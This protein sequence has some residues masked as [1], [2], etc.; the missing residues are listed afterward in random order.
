MRNELAEI[1]VCCKSI[2][3]NTSELLNWEWDDY[4]G[5]FLA[6][7]GQQEAE[8]IEAICDQCFMSRWDAAALGDIP[9]DVMAVAESLGGLRNRQQLMVTAPGDFLTA[10]GAWWPWGDGKT[11]SLRIGLIIHGKV[12]EHAGAEFT[13]EFREWFTTK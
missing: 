12:P 11:I 5:A 10:Y 4:I 8:A 1:E 7:F 2:I 3:E 13:Q 6:T 9:A